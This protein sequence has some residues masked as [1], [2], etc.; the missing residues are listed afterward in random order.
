MTHLFVVWLHLVAAVVLTGLA[1]YWTILRLA[2]PRFAA[3]TDMM[4]LL[5]AAHAARWPHVA[6][7]WSLRMPL[8]WLGLLITLFLAASGLLLG[9]AA[10]DSG[11]WRA[12]LACVALL[13]LIQLAFLRRIADWILFAQL[14]LVLLITLLSA[15][16]LRS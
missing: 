8:P 1:L 14:P 7:P 3:G 4:A 13:A 5:Q 6:V 16:A 10:A 9:G 11:L 15:L 12:K 2:L